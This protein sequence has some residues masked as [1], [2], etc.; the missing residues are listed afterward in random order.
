MNVAAIDIGTNS[1]N[2]LIVD[3]DGGE[4]TRQIGITRLG[5]GVDRTGRLADDAIART[6]AQLAGY[7]ELLTEHGVEH[8][9]A[10]ATSASRDAANRDDFFT[11]AEAVIG[12]RPTLISG[13]EE[14][15]LAYRGAVSDRPDGEY[16]LVVDI[17]GGSTELMLGDA[18]L[19]GVTSIDVGAVRLTEAHL[20]SDPPR[21]EELTN[22]IGAVQDLLDDVE[23]KLPG[24]AARPMLLGIAG[25]ITTI[26]A[27]EVGLP[28]YDPTRVHGLTL[29]RSAIEE[30]FRTLATEPLADRIHNPGLPRE[31]ADVI[32]GG[33]C[34][35][36]A[37]MRSWH[38]DELVVSNRTLLDGVC[39]G[40]L[41]ELRSER[42]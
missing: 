32:V 4:V 30:V 2:L 3:A 35:L 1:T 33:C 7:R 42:R 17:G 21:A 29:P 39:A 37:L 9:R 15:A 34:V 25:T 8:V 24:L 14:G 20:H 10:V 19:R 27:V 12:V 41:D 23:R 36:V 22:A 13:D 38:I 18:E 16:R 28:V 26:A 6:V 11:Q 40:L 31:R 5:A